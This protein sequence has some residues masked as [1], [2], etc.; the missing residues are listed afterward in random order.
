MFGVSARTEILRYFI[1]HE[2][3][4]ASVATLAAASGYTK[5]NIA[6]ECTT[7]ERAGVLTVRS[8][9]NRLYYSLERDAQL[10]AFIGEPPAVLPDWTTLFRVSRALVNLSDS[11]GR[12]PTRALNVEASRTISD[13]AEDLDLLELPSPILANDSWSA[14]QRFAE[15]TLK[16]WARGQWHSSR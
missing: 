9:T 10:R 1:S 13:L 12:L 3:G 14:V 2:R 6:D 4:R 7:L 8:Q 16:A 5:R 11:A 15:D